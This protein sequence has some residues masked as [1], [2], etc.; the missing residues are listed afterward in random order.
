MK[1]NVGHTSGQREKSEGVLP[2]SRGG[3]GR[4]DPAA[5]RFLDTHLSLWQTSPTDGAE[6]HQKSEE[7]SGFYG[8]I[9]GVAP[10]VHRKTIIAAPRQHANDSKCFPFPDSLGP[11]YHVHQEQ[12]QHICPETLD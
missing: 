8:K 1:A 9:K 11:S 10:N 4:V 3:I 2:K 7:A 5:V 12:D 6:P